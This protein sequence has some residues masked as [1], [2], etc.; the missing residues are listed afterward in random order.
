MMENLWLVKFYG[1]IL[2]PMARANHKLP[3]TENSA[4]ELK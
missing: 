2:Q 1:L 3:I 4:F